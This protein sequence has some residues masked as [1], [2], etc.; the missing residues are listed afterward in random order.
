MLG[1]SVNLH[2]MVVTAAALLV[3]GAAFTA[4]AQRQ[5]RVIIRSASQLDNDPEVRKLAQPYQSF[6]ALKIIQA[7]CSSVIPFT[8]EQNKFLNAKYADLSKRYMAAYIDAYMAQIK[9]PPEQAFVDDVVKT[10]TANQ[11]KAV[12]SMTSV[13]QGKRGC[14]SGQLKPFVK[15][16]EQVR[17]QDAADAVAADAARHSPFSLPK[18]H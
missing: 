12:N 5:R 7:Q 11:Q 14:A 4:E 15:Y 3:V 9:A 18:Q 1:V 16:M 10:V 2:K 13:V 8:A 17:K 6:S